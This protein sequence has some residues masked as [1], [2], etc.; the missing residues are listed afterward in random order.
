MGTV[1]LA[2]E[3]PTGTALVVK[4]LRVD[5][6]EL[7]D[8]FRGEFALLSRLTHPRLAR[9]L[10]L[11]SERLRGELVHYYV[12]EHVEG[13]TLGER[14]RTGLSTPELMGP[15]L[16]ALEGLAVLHG[17]GIRHG[18]FTLSNVLIG[19]DGSGTLID[20]GCARPFGISEVLAGTE[21]Y[22]A[23][24]LLER[25]AGDARADLFAVGVTIQ[26]A[27]ALA[28][29][30]LGEPLGRVVERLLRPDPNQRP[31]EV[32]EVLEALGRRIQPQKQLFAPP[33]LVGRA[34][35]LSLFA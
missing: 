7:L 34:H 11:G 31:T 29:Q 18:D 15:T 4:Q 35:E 32:A 6:P 1:F 16:D 9:V 12:A 13:S 8:S 26:R 5:A 28:G 30:P 24:E 33:E 23:P 25:G 21:G 27:W 22:L 3:E 17:A 19:A 10:E 20:L 2:H 14:A